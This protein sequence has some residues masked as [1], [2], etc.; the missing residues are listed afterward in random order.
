MSVKVAEVAFVKTDG[1]VIAI[2]A[3]KD[4]IGI[5]DSNPGGGVSLRRCGRR[6]II[7][8]RELAR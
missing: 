2:D 7:F 1:F 6:N 5:E 8:S 4:E 3:N